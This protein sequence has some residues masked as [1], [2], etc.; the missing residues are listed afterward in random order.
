VTNK[1]SIRKCP[2]EMRLTDPTTR[3]LNFFDR[4]GTT[5]RIGTSP[6]CSC[7]PEEMGEAKAKGQYQY[8]RCESVVCDVRGP[9]SLVMTW[10]RPR[11][12]ARKQDLAARQAHMTFMK[13][14]P[15]TEHRL[16]CFVTVTEGGAPWRR[17]HGVLHTFT[18][19][20]SAYNNRKRAGDE[21]LKWSRCCGE[22]SRGQARSATTQHRKS[23]SYPGT[24]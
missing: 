16:F 23:V 9:H 3:S 24:G 13:L 19:Q 20:L 15:G 8:A 2:F 11:R 4:L 21:A 5:E 10:R 17:F 14:T 6:T 12:P 18:K 22:G 1:S 7:E